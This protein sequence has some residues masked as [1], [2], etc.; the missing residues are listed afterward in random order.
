VGVFVVVGVGAGNVCV[1]GWVCKLL[2][3]VWLGGVALNHQQGIG[4]LVIRACVSNENVL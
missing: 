2:S 3:L 4:C 1:C